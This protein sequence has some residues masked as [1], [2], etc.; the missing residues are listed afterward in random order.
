MPAVS[1]FDDYKLT[2]TVTSP[3]NPTQHNG[4]DSLAANVP[5]SRAGTVIVIP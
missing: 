5:R 3:L 4:H 2:A 1:R